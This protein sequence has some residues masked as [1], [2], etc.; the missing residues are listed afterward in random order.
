M[1]S[2]RHMAS[3]PRGQCSVTMQGMDVL[4]KLESRI[5][6]LLAHLSSLKEEN[7]RC[8]EELATL[9]RENINLTREN[10]V[11]RE[12]IA[13]QDALRLEAHRRLHKVLLSIRD[14]GTGA[15]SS[16]S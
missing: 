14:Y 5:E 15:H 10:G 16:E 7:S 2:V 4:G 13:R 6:Q 8:R 9:R 1:P 3:L 12:S 11:L